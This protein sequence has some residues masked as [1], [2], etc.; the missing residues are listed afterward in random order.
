LRLY[1]ITQVDS[2]ALYADHR[3]TSLAVIG[4]RVSKA[5]GLGGAARGVVLRVEI[6]HHR[7]AA[8]LRQRDRAVA[9]GRQ[10]EIRGLVAD[11]DAHRAVSPSLLSSICAARRAGRS[12]RRS[13]QSRIRAEAA[14]ISAS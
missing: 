4:K 11:L 9:V 7:L 14:V 12:I 5:A 6:Q 3:R 8:Q 10:C 13:Y 2:D 1:T